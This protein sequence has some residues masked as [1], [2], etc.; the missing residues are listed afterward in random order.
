MAGKFRFFPDTKCQIVD[1]HDDSCSSQGYSLRIHYRHTPKY[2]NI[3]N[4]KKVI[5]FIRKKGALIEFVLT[6]PSYRSDV[7]LNKIAGI[8]PRGLLH[9]FGIGRTHASDIKTVKK[10]WGRV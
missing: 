5:K 7:C 1:C 6:L 4:V 2:N 9:A 3:E 8:V 10:R